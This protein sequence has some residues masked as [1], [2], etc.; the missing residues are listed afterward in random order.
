[1]PQ[2]QRIKAMV[3]IP[4]QEDPDD[5]YTLGC[6]EWLNKLG[7]DNLPDKPC[8]QAEWDKPLYCARQKNLLD[9]ATSDIMMK[10]NSVSVESPLSQ[11]AEARVYQSNETELR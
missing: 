3:P 1:M 5:Y 6:N 9:S 2:N 7:R 11:K 10:R 4:I 8:F